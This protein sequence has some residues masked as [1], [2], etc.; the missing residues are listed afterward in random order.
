M[1]ILPSKTSRLNAF[2]A[3][4]R[5]QNRFSTPRNIIPHITVEGSLIAKSEN[6]IIHHEVNVS[7]LSSHLAEIGAFVHG[8]RPGE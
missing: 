8:T 2:I 1:Y 3:I 4:V 5:I 7:V 6:L